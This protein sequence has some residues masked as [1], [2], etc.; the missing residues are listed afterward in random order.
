ML[1]S[2]RGASAWRALDIEIQ[3]WSLLS[4]GRTGEAMKKRA[5]CAAHVHKVED[6]R[7]R[8]DLREDKQR[9][10]TNGVKPSG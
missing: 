10:R 2:V 1:R 4:G 8:L 7:R 9:L 6:S 5:A 3:R